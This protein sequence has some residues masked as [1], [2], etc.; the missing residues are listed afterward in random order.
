MIG[1]AA[2]NSHGKSQPPLN[3]A[4][5]IAT[6]SDRILQRS[7]LLGDHR[8]EFPPDRVVAAGL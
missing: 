2:Q 4:R 6:G 7:V 1:D 3:S 5:N 8:A